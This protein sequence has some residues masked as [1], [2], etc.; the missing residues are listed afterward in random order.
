MNVVLTEPLGWI[1]M[2]LL[3]Y[4]YARSETL[5]PER[6]FFANFVGAIL[7]AVSLAA[8]NAWPALFLQ[9]VWAFVAIRD[10]RRALRAS[11]DPS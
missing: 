11:K 7:L 2:I 4:G 9:G 10:L 3:V 6:R 1:G 8:V 5:S